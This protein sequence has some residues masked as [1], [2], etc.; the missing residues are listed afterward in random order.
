MMIDTLD[1][2]VAAT[3]KLMDEGTE[4]NWMLDKM[5]ATASPIYTEF[6]GRLPDRMVSKLISDIVELGF[7][8]N[9]ENPGTYKYFLYQYDAEY[10]LKVE[11]NRSGEKATVTLTREEVN[12]KAEV[13]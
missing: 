7:E 12:M 8:R 1:K 2:A 4:L 5:E 6:S 9:R 3:T 10:V 13:A 11:R